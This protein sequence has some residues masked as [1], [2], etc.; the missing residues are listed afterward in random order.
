MGVIASI[1]SQFGIGG[2]M[3][4]TIALRAVVALLISL[5]AGIAPCQSVLS[6]D[7]NVEPEIIDVSALTL[8]P[9]RGAQRPPSLLPRPH[10]PL[11]SEANDPGAAHVLL[12]DIPFNATHNAAAS[13]ANLWERIRGSFGMQE[14][15]SP[16]VKEWENWY[17]SRPDYLARMIARGERYLFYVVEEV[18]RR[19]MP[20]EIVLLP[21]IE[22]AYNPTA[23]SSAHAAG[24]WQFI[25][26][27]GKTYGLKQNWWQDERRDVLAATR[28]A[29]DYL[30]KLYEMFGSWEL[31]LASYNW[32]EGA[33]GRAIQRNEA[34]GLPGDYLSLE[35][36]AETRNYV[37][38]LM[39]VKNLI[40]RPD[41][42]GIALS[43]IDNR[44]Y[45]A[46][47]STDKHI[48][49]KIA[50]KLAEMPLADFEA[51]N[52]SHNRP[53]I[54]ADVA[55][56]ILVPADR[57]AT[58]QSNLE[59]HG[60]KLT[61]WQSYTIGKE[62]RLEKIAQRFGI[63]LAQ[64]KEVNSIPARLRSLVGLTIL[65]PDN[66]EVPGGNVGAAGFA[67]PPS[68]EPSIVAT[69]V[70]H[71]VRAGETLAG[72][73]Q[74]YRT[75][76]A[77]LARSNNIRNGKVLIGQTLVVAETSGRTAA[78]APQRATTVRQSETTKAVA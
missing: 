56:P 10:L 76:V 27:T 11:H 43:H 30:E 33:V 23:Y 50:A 17:A 28:A 39:A 26:S 16:L 61:T 19:G 77:Q 49:V 31:A 34:R 42:F 54:R 67:A 2:G 74:R 53:V 64:L 25:P 62:D 38:K 36:P 71:V 20:S 35:M 58:F 8:V 21:M 68:P 70:K 9:E 69:V 40:A 3:Y 18:E 46:V 14:L 63:A 7:I 66:Q 51:L 75:T 41:D 48:D 29:L 12:N 15:P 60:P 22:S 57:A 13:A 6:D 4:R 32:G 45:F 1:S 37:P 5:H 44:P 47:V 73:A 55:Q 24:M 78:P 65:V 52:P 72:I 59:A